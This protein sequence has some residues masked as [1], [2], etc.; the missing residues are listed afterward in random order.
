[1]RTKFTF[2]LAAAGVALLVMSAPGAAE[3]ATVNLP[4]CDD[5]YVD[6]ASPNTN[7]GT[8]LD[9]YVGDRASQTGGVCTSF[10]QFDLSAVPANAEIVNAELWLCKHEKYGSPEQT[11]TVQVHLITTPGWNEGAVTFNAPPGYAT[12]PTAAITGTFNPPGWEYWNVTGD[13]AAQR[14]SGTLIGWAVLMNPLPQWAW[15]N[16]NTSEQV[17]MPDERPML[18]VTYSGAVPAEATSWSNVKALFH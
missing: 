17:P 9:T 11:F 7:F 15:L 13:V 12:A 1:M 14:P 18:E 10:Y 8:A 16:F 4:A 2:A 6:S 5:A 3:F